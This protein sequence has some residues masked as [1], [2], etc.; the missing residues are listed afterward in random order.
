MKFPHYCQLDAMDCGPS[1]LRMIAKYYGR[2]YTLQTLRER[3]FITREGVSMLGISDAAEYIGFR[4]I[5]VR[6]SFDQLIKE[7]NLPCI[8][9]WNQN[10]FVVCYRIECH[11][12]G[13]VSLYIADPASRKLIYHKE[14]F[15]R[16]WISKKE[17]STDTGTALLLEP[18]P[19]FDSIDDEKRSSRRDFAFFV[20]YLLPYKSQ[21]AQLIIG[22]L[23]GSGIQMIFP[24]LTQALVD[25]GIR[26]RNLS[27]ITLILITQLLLFISQLAVGFIRS[28]IMLHINSRIDIA[29]ISDFLMKLM[30]LPL[31]YFDTKM[32][33]DI[34]QRIGD[35]GRIK[36]FLMGSSINIIFS[37]FNFIIFS[38]I[39]GYYNWMILVIF[40][41]G[42]TL[43][44]IWILAFMKYRRILDIKRFNQSAG[45]QSKIIQLIQGMQ[46]IKL[47]NCEKQKR[48]EWE[49]IQVKLFKI[50]VKGLTIGQIQQTG[51]V[52]FTQSTSIIVSFIAAKA[53]VD[54]NMT[55]GMMMSLTYIIGQVSAPIGEFIGFAQSYQDAKISLERLNEIHRKRDEEF[56]ITSKLNYLP[57]V[58][59]IYFEN[60]T[61]SY[62]GADRDYALEDVTLTIPQHKVTAIVGSSGSGKTTLVKLLQGFYSP[63]RGNI[64]IGSTPLKMINPHLWRSK[65]GSVMQESYIFSD[66]IAKNIAISTDEVNIE[67]LRHAVQ[68]ANIQDFIND[69]PMAYDTKIGMEGSGISQGQRQRILIARAVYKDPEYIFLDEATNSL[70]ANNEKIIMDNLQEFYKGRTVFIVAHRLSTVRNAD[71]IIVLEK[72]KIVEQGTHEELTIKHGAYYTLV[73]N[74]LELGK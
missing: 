56:N 15:L 1:C 32:T 16:C 12:N 71:N 45:E 33:G 25:T 22:M 72:G 30:T 70:D 54:G 49:R 51:S 29:L 6:I 19:L 27:F 41:F 46:E 62:S 67:R 61:F 47:N 63:N 57:E 4:T 28:W 40:L 21:F 7:A 10:H 35:H 73:K 24:F 13:E 18:S 52:F 31:H 36:S 50:G 66:T 2:S 8:L 44:M 65:T 23:V 64:R 26:D 3:C 55:L 39:L 11:K 74:Q 43:Y 59:D 5:G 42:N 38:I 69:L 37:F 48:W 17:N 53:V 34:M 68:V 58:R 9:H 60:V 20:K 14:E